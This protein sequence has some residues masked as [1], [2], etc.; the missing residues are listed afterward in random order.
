MSST[1]RC[2]GIRVTVPVTW[3]DDNNAGVDMLEDI[4]NVFRRKAVAP[5]PE[6]VAW[7]AWLVKHEQENMEK[8]MADVLHKGTLPF[9]HRHDTQRSS[10][11]ADHV[12]T[13]SEMDT[14]TAECCVRLLH[15]ALFLVHISLHR[16]MESAQT[17]ASIEATYFDWHTKRGAH[18]FF[19][20]SA[21]TCDPYYFH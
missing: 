4:W 12:F 16:T 3:S 1:T 14:Y 13:I 17:G 20:V 6:D 19:V 9:L 11:S 2:L 21:E 5:S 7:P 15:C 8:E 18:E 10:P